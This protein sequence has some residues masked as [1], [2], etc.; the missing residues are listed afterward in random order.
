MRARSWCGPPAGATALPTGSPRA[1]DS[2]ADWPVL[3][4]P[5]HGIRFGRSPKYGAVASWAQGR[6]QAWL[7]DVYGGKD[8]NWAEDRRDDDKLPTLLHSIDPTRGLQRADIDD[9][10][11]R[12]RSIV[13]M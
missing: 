11:A 4:V 12:M 13:G 5:T 3:P 7:D 9:V 2:A 1:S 10:L 8:V 6:P